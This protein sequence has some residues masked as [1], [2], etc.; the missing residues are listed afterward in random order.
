MDSVLRVILVAVSDPL[1]PASSRVNLFSLQWN[2]GA[3][4]EH[5]G[6]YRMTSNCTPE[7]AVSEGWCLARDQ[8]ST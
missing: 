7:R 1:P 5:Y 6:T 3:Q 2:A 4:P 8:H